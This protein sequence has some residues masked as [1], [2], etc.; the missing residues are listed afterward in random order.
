MLELEARRGVHV[1]MLPSNQRDP[2][3]T[4]PVQHGDPKEADLEWRG[5]T[6]QQPYTHVDSDV[7]HLCVL[8]AGVVQPDFLRQHNC[9]VTEELARAV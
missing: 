6:A 8:C 2:A 3:L 5:W 9:P 4:G 1:G 7:L